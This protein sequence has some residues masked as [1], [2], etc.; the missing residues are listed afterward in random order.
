MQFGTILSDQRRLRGLSQLQLSNA[1]GVSQRHISFLE[2][3]RAKPGRAATARL[4]AAL[5]LHRHEADAL[6]TAAGLRAPSAVPA[7]SDP[8]FAAVRAATRLLIDSHE[9]WPAIICDHAGTIL[10][11]NAAFDRVMVLAGGN[12]MLATT[13]HNLYDLTL[14]PQGLYPLMDN[15]EAIVPHTLLRLR[16]A[17]ASDP[18][19]R[20]TLMRVGDWPNVSTHGAISAPDGGGALCERYRIGDMTIAIHSMTTCFGCPED[21]TAQVIQIEL[22]LPADNATRSLFGKL[23]TP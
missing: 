4:V 2:S 6:L 17:A 14:H 19:A 15:P 7:W 13:G 10:A 8:A 3:G 18:A 12:A 5:A 9:P 11:T 21:A 23:A 1:S 20:Q 16:R 22:F